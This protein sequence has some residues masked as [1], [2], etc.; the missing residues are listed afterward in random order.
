MREFLTCDGVLMVRIAATEPDSYAPN[1]EHMGERMAV[2]M[3][4]ATLVELKE[5]QG[6][7]NVSMKGKT[8]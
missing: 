1:G 2:T 6:L 8:K 4:P 7:H 3:R 5:Y